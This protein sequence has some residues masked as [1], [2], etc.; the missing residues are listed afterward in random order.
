MTGFKETDRKAPEMNTSVT[1][2]GTMGLFTT[3]QG[4]AAI[5]HDAARK[6]RELQKRAEQLNSRV[7]AREKLLNN[8]PGLRARSGT[9]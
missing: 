3:T 1:N 2:P 4:T 6:T 5:I 9:S 7:Q 8:G